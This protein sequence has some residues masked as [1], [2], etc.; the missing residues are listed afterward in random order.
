MHPDVIA[1]TNPDRLALITDD[2]RTRTYAQ[3]TAAAWRIAR[4]FRSLGLQPGDHVAL[5]R[6]PPAGGRCRGSRSA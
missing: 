5:S 1:K 3:L 4:L 2:G 6:S